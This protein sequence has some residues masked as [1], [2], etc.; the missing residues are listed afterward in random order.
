MRRRQFLGVLG[1]AVAWPV[2]AKAQTGERTRV[3]GV[4][5]VLASDDPVSK[6]RNEVFAQALQLGWSVGVSCLGALVLTGIVY[7]CGP[8]EWPF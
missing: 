3:V 4:L 2:A 1:W 6:T 5:H 7:T 8:F